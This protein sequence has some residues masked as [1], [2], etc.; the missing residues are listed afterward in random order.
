MRTDE[1]GGGFDHV[2]ED[3]FERQLSDQRG[4]GDDQSLEALLRARGRG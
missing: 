2:L 1:V 4:G 3:A